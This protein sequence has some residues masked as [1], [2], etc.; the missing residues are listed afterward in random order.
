MLQ[1]EKCV[2]VMH[3]LDETVAWLFGAPHADLGNA[4]RLAGQTSDWRFCSS[5]Q[6]CSSILPLNKKLLVKTRRKSELTGTPELFAT[7]TGS[8]P[9]CITVATIA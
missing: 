7:C 4:C 8:I 9:S 6:R 5:R 2:Y 3:L 1:R